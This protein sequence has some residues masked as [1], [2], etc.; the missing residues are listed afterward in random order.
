MPCYRDFISFLRVFQGRGWN[1][2]RKRILIFFGCTVFRRQCIAPAELIL[3]RDGY[4]RK[5]YLPLCLLYY[6]RTIGKPIILSFRSRRGGREIL[7]S[8]TAR[9]LIPPC[10]I[11]DDIFVPPRRDQRSHFICSFWAIVFINLT[12][13]LSCDISVFISPTSLPES[14]SMNCDFFIMN[15]CD[16]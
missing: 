4:A 11:R 6:F 9:S 3:P 7:P 16:G 15:T 10:G 12:V 13:L 14:K 5:T 2:P 8:V 1:Q